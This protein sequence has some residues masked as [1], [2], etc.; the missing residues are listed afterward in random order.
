LRCMNLYW[1]YDASSNVVTIEHISWAGWS[2][3][4]GTDIRTQEIA[5]ANNKY[6]YIKEDLPKWEKFDWMEADND[7]FL[8]GTIRYDS[9]CVDQD[10]STNI[11]EYAWDV[12]TDIQYICD[13][14]EDV[15]S[16]GLISNISDE[17][18]VLLANYLDGGGDLQIWMTNRPMGNTYFNCDLGW[19][20]LLISFFKH[21]RSVI[22]GYMNGTLTTF[23]TTR[24]TRKQDTNM[25]YCDDFDPKKY[26]TTELGETYFGGIKGYVKTATIQPDGLIKLSLIYGQEENTNTGFSYGKGMIITEVKTSFPDNTRYTAVLTEPADGAL[27]MKIKLVL[28]DSDTP[29]VDFATAWFDLDILLGATTGFVD[30]PWGDPGVS[31]YREHI[32]PWF[33]DVGLGTWDWTFVLDPAAY[34]Y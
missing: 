2:G 10:S 27:Q 33:D 26:I 31:P 17:G 16:E 14:I 4:A 1:T 11:D 25:I 34:N 8:Q 23:Y 9:A 20:I 21:E 30:I 6:S 12:T 5:L 18:F 13:C 22:E 24:K 32:T 19:G 28:Q 3:T 15:S 29:P 7:E